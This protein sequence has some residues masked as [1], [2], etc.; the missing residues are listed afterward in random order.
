MTKPTL[1]FVDDEQH[2]LNAMNWL[3][4]KNYN[5]IF[6]DSGEKAVELLKT[7]EVDVIVSDQKM[8]GMR[9]TELLKAA[10]E[11]S[12]S[13]IRLL[14]T[15]YSDYSAAL[16]SINDGEVFRFIQKPWNNFKLKDT[17]EEAVHI[18]LSAHEEIASEIEVESI[19][20]EVPAGVLVI[21]PTNTLQPQIIPALEGSVPTFSTESLKD[22]IAMLQTKNI[23]I[24]VIEHCNRTRQIVDFIKMMKQHHPE[25]IAIVACENEDINDVIDLINAGQV[26]RF[27]RMPIRP[28]MI[29]MAIE[30]G[31]KHHKALCNKPK[32]RGRHKVDSTMFDEQFSKPSSELREVKEGHEFSFFDLINKIRNLKKS[33]SSVH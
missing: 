5:L 16:A 18:S 28:A 13:T 26:F 1:M 21:D 20:P 10:R 3:F 22:A 29:K 6:A 27:I 30:S 2:I 19:E 7:N 11:I 9:G 23:G 33:S 25:I 15:G 4:R 14:L 31:L 24:M 17:I 32:L 8:P 12:P